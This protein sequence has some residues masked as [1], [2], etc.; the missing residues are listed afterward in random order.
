M[1]IRIP[2]NYKPD[3][4]DCPVCNIAFMSRADV[5]N[6]HVHGCCLQC[7]IKYRYPNADKWKRGWR[8]QG[9]GNET[10]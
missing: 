9:E 8:P 5:S 2:D 6:Y 4:K 7:D 10:N 3:T 1:I